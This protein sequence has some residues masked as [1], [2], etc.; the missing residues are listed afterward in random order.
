MRNDRAQENPKQ[1][2]GDGDGE[3]EPGLNQ[4]SSQAGQQCDQQGRAFFGHAVCLGL[5]R[6]VEKQ[7]QRI[8]CQAGHQPDLHAERGKP[9]PSQALSP[10][11]T[12]LTEA[13]KTNPHWM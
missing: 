11:A 8:G 13:S 7:D 12:T 9:P 3:R 5:G 1:G 2:G 10:I 4:V 6:P